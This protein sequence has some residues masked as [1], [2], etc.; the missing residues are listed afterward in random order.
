MSP[1]LA[2]PRL[3]LA[4]T[5][6]LALASTVS[7]AGKKCIDS[8]DS[9]TEI[10][11]QAETADVFVRVE[12][13]DDD[14]DDDLTQY[15]EVCDSYER[16]SDQR[17]EAVV[18]GKVSGED[19]EELAKKLRA[20]DEN[21]DG[22]SSSTSSH[23][24]LIKK[25]TVVKKKEGGLLSLSLSLSKN[26]IHYDGEPTAKALVEYLKQE[27]GATIGNFVFSLGLL[28]VLA[29]QFAKVDTI[30]DDEQNNGSYNYYS[31]HLKK[32]VLAYTAKFLSYTLHIGASDEIKAVVDMYVRAFF[33]SLK[34][35]DYA[36][37]QTARI[38]KLMESSSQ[39]MSAKK[40]EQMTQKLH[41]LTRFTN[42]Q[43]RPEQ[44]RQ[45]YISVGLNVV[46][47]V[48][49]VMLVIQFIIGDGD[50]KEESQ[51]EDTKEV[52]GEEDTT[53]ED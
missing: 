41:V 42:P 7:A 1:F 21:N 26:L 46:V 25:G 8:F 33:Q 9:L 53:K 6:L 10:L 3:L 24:V 51:S 39:N 12:F 32:R 37:Q 34:Q 19:Q 29:A 16:T 35:A 49:V 50:D 45:F 13:A 47:L 4:L 5:T 48:M 22:E 38:Q 28:D 18:I 17:K 15:Q 36:S 44:E 30:I 11:T 40:W 31:N 52:E 43:V 2:P 27:T 23:Y 20:D 14:D